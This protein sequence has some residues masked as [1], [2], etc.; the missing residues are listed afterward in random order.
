MFFK[1][2]GGT[3][4]ILSDIFDKAVVGGSI[5]FGSALEFND[6]FEFKFRSIAPSK[7]IFDRWHEEYQPLRTPEELKNAWEAF[8]GS[9][10]SWNTSFQPRV[11]ALSG[12][13]VLCLATRWNSSLMWAHY[14][15][16]HRGFAIRYKAE[17][18]DALR[19]SADHVASGPVR[20]QGEIPELRWFSAPPSELL[21][22]ILFTKSAEWSYEEEYRV[23]VA[24]VDGTS[25]VFRSI[26]PSL[27]SGIIL[28]ARAPT[29]LVRKALN[30]REKRSD[31]SVEQ[32]LSSS[33]SYDMVVHTVDGSVRMFSQFL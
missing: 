30:L 29:A 32:V 27:I 13:F 4:E 8:S 1:F 22:P 28:G 33:D 11:N 6:P 23:V 9:G 15:A 17:V 20:Y 24:V 25:A 14:T 31:F 2:V 7:E 26:D 18:I 12:F 3:D 10:V 21:Q 19:N 16:T 5:K